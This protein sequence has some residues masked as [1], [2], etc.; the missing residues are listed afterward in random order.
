MGTGAEWWLMAVPG[1][2][3]SHAGL[4]ESAGVAASSMQ[5]LL[6]CAPCSALRLFAGL[7]LEPTCQPHAPQKSASSV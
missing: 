2:P 5:T 6:L 4:E 7:S 3:H 1:L